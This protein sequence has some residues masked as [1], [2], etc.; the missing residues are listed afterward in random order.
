MIDKTTFL[1]KTHK[2]K[3]VVQDKERGIKAISKMSEEEYHNYGFRGIDVT[4]TMKEIIKKIK[5]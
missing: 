4:N 1:K 3:I 2:V 5:L